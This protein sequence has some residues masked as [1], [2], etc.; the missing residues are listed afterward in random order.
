MTDPEPQPSPSPPPP[1]PPFQ[2]RLRTLL[3]VVTLFAF[4]CSWLAVKREQGMAAQVKALQKERIDVLTTLVEDYTSQFRVGTSPNEFLIG[5]ET[6]LVNAQLA[7]TDNPEQRVA[8][9]TEALKR[10][11]EIMKFASPVCGRDEVDVEWWR[12]ISLYTQIRLL[13]VQKSPAVQIRA[14]QKERIEALTKVVQIRES[15]YWVG[16]IDREAVVSA[17][18]ALVDA[19]VDATGNRDERVALLTQ[20]LKRESALL[21]IAGSRF[22]AG[23]VTEGDVNRARSLLL[24]TKIRLLRDGRREDMADQLKAAHKERV[25]T[26]ITLVKHDE[27]HYRAGV[28]DCESVVNTETALVN[29][30]VEATDS[31][32]ERVALLTEALKRETALSKIVDGRLQAGSVSEADVYRARLLLL[33]ARIRLL[34]EGSLWGAATK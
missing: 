32:D 17:E 19:Q 23:S 18:A 25:E 22:G 9:L 27:A 1:R 30:Q 4:I 8:V 20:A 10:E 7:A 11:R 2:F 31:R 21:E 15:Q 34:R 3:I 33:D 29:A 13:R 5:A 6:D 16:T 14:L 24:T 28:T 26:L 12:S